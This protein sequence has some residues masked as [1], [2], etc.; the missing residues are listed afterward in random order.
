MNSSAPTQRLE[1]VDQAKGFGMICVVYGHLLPK[2]PDV[3]VVYAF[4]IPLFFFLSGFVSN[5]DKYQSLGAFAR[6]RLHSLL[7]PYLS[8]GLLAYVYGQLLLTIGHGRLVAESPWQP[9]IGLLLG[10]RRTS[11]FNGTLWFLMCLFIAECMSYLLRR[12][13]RRFQA[14]PWVATCA[15]F[16]LGCFYNQS[17]KAPFFFSADAAAMALVFLQLGMLYRKH[18]PKIEKLETYKAYWLVLLLLF[19][20]GFVGNPEH[21][22][23]YDST[24]GNYLWF[25]VTAV[26]GIHLV[27]IVAKNF[28]HFSLLNYIGKNTLGI[29]CFHKWL[30][31]GLVNAALAALQW[32]CVT[33]NVMLVRLDAVIRMALVLLITCALCEVLTR[34]VPFVLGKRKKAPAG[35]SR[36]AGS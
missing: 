10:I 17:T 26:T 4:H 35:C 16:G 21:V 25:L 19:A 29:L 18:Q 1:W 32:H 34:Y 22:D 6:Q 13:E 23:M 3:N 30:V 5:F 14:V 27:I 33:S 8:I 12:A 7:I 31:I 24:Y 9:L 20:I 11:N 2:T 28:F 15:I 36:P